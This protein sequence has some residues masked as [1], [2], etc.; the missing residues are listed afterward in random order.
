MI[1]CIHQ[2]ACNRC[3]M[4]LLCACSPDGKWGAPSAAGQWQARIRA[5]SGDF[6]HCWHIRPTQP[7][8][9]VL[10]GA[11]LAHGQGLPSPVSE[12][13]QTKIQLRQFTKHVIVSKFQWRI[14]RLCEMLKALR[15]SWIVPETFKQKVLYLTVAQYRNITMSSLCC[16]E[17]W[18]LGC[19]KKNQPSHLNNVPDEIYSNPEIPISR[20]VIFGL[21]Q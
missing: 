9:P 4:C 1:L 8:L 21:C 16:G 18:V 2:H 7:P 13:C 5:P 3:Q 15:G 19:C 14:L 20:T 12:H 11:G 17:I 10:W 6:P